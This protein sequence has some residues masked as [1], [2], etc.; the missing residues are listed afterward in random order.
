MSFLSLV[1]EVT[2]VVPGLSQVLARNMV[3]RAWRAIRDE[4]L[5]SFLM[6]SGTVVCP[7]QI[8]AGTVSVTNNSTT[9]TFDTA[10][11]AAL[12]PSV[13]GN[14]PLTQLQFRVNGQSL[15]QIVAV[16]ATSP[17]LVVILDLPYR[18]ATGTG[19]QYQVYRA[20]VQAPVTD[21]LTW[22]S[23]DDFQNGYTIERDRLTRRRED[24]DRWDPQRQSQGQA[25]NL[26]A[27]QT[28]ASVQDTPLWELWPHPVQGQT[29]VTAFRRQGPDFA[30]PTDVQPTM[31]PD[32]LILA[33]TLA[34]G[35]YPWAQANKGKFPDLNGTDFL[36]LK[37]DAEADYGRMIT[38]AKRQDDEI[39][40]QRVYHRGRFARGWRQLNGPA[41]AAYWQ[42][43]AISW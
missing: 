4:R 1:S 34:W 5:W 16:T 7:V 10:A 25:Y 42:H 36:S 19:Q 23:F 11:T 21:F 24:F 8:T 15:Y 32:E 38:I 6:A 39:A 12:V 41:D 28:G 40:L 18:E 35:A 27:Y 9:V 33:R 43:S 37:K 30:L 13:T 29:F 22:I 26:G 3:T 14:P 31:I 20:Y 17:H 2:G